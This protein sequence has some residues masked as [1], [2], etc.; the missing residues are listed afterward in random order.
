VAGHDSQHK[1]ERG[2]GGDLDQ[3]EH[4][5]REAQRPHAGR[6]AR[7]AVDDR[8]PDDVGAPAGEGESNDRGASGCCRERNHLR[9]LVQREEPSPRANLEGVGDKE[10]KPRRGEETR[11]SARERPRSIGEAT[12][13]QDRQGERH[14]SRSSGERQPGPRRTAEAPESTLE[15]QATPARA[16]DRGSE[17]GDLDAH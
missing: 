5:E 8:D 14:S 2:Q 1:G 4:D 12:G 17:N 10:E 11:M 16:N 15:R 6:T 9:A 13:S 3:A 7:V